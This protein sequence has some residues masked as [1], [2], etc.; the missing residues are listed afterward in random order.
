MRRVENLEARRFGTVWVP[1]RGQVAKLQESCRQLQ[2]RLDFWEVGSEALLSQTAAQLLSWQQALREAS[3]AAL[4]RLT[5]RRVALLVAGH[6]EAALCKI[7]YDRAA[8][9]ALLPCR[10]HA[11]C[12]RCAERLEQ[13]PMCRTAVTGRFETFSG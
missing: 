11:F 12:G 1:R 8:S 4:E 10:H 7:C 5:E 13:C 2:E 6:R 9:C 3:A